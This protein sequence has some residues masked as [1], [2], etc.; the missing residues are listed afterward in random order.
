MNTKT[1]IIIA[2]LV[3]AGTGAFVARSIGKTETP[4]SSSGTEPGSAIAKPALSVLTV[5]PDTR[6]MARRLSANGSVAAWQEAS[7][8][9]EVNGLRLVEVRVNVGTQVKRGDVLAEFA[10]ETPLAEQAQVRAS[11]AEAQA[12]L[13]EAHANAER[14]RAIE[15][16]GALSAQQISQYLTAEAT[17]R[18][19]LQAAKAN[20]AVADLRLAHT[21]V[22]A[23]DDGVISLRSPAATVGAVVPQGQ[24]LFRLIRQ[25]RL[26]WRAEVT[27]DELGRIRP[28]QDVSIAAASGV[29]AIG[30]VRMVAPTVDTQTRNAL[31]YVD[32]PASATAGAN[33]AFKAGMFARG[34]F[35]MGK[36][37]GLT[38]PRQAVVMR[39][40][41]SYVFLIGKE[42]RVVQAKVQVGRRDSERAEITGGLQ[43]DALVVAS[44]AGFLNDGDLVKVVEA[45]A[46]TTASPAGS[47]GAAARQ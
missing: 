15:N 38:L 30:K 21:R 45:G 11:L 10:S 43:A 3:V 6:E 18:A 29:T 12:A 33:A 31:V 24:E 9:S 40:G 25:N 13:Q 32:L 36:T 23:S 26:E 8:G 7:L 22:L 17:A 35:D 5:R 27:A 16:T 47:S 1:K 20:L 41:F 4:P 28:G 42:N 19:R 46:G 2:L 44:G 39:D 14:A 37:R 34:E